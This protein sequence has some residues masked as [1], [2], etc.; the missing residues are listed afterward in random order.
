MW[1]LRKAGKILGRT[2]KQWTVEWWECI[3]AT[4]VSANP[5]YDLQGGH[6]PVGQRGPVWFLCG[7]FN[8]SQGVERTIAVPEGTSLLFP[9]LNVEWDNQGLLAP[10]S[11]EQLRG[12][13]AEF[14]AAVRPESLF[15]ELD[16]VRLGTNSIV[17]IES[18]D[19]VFAFPEDSVGRAFGFEGRRGIYGPAVA[20]GWWTML[21]PLP[22]GRHTLHF[23][24][25][26]GAP[27]AFTLDIRYT[28]DVV[29]TGAE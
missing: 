20:D 21:R 7:A 10:L 19:F 9:L 2:P 13:V 26:A 8:A 28:I 29:E 22:P 4:P 15:V 12:L 1:D 18:P 27:F 6:A 5:A 25:D 3:H 14:M 23:G 11:P 16:G 24:G 17:R